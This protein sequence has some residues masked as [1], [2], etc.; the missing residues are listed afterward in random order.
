MLIIGQS[1]VVPPPPQTPAQ[2]QIRDTF[3]VTA[4]VLFL[5]TSLSYATISP[6]SPSRLYAFWFPSVSAFHFITVI[7]LMEKIRFGTCGSMFHILGMRGSDEEGETPDWSENEPP[8][9]PRFVVASASTQSL[10]APPFFHFTSVGFLTTH[11]G[12]ID[13]PS[14]PR[15]RAASH[16]SA[17]TDPQSRPR[18][19]T[20]ITGQ[21]LLSYSKVLLHIFILK[22]ECGWGLTAPRPALPCG[23]AICILQCGVASIWCQLEVLHRAKAAAAARLMKILKGA[24]CAE[25]FERRELT[26]VDPTG[27]RRKRQVFGSHS[28]GAAGGGCT[29][30]LGDLF[31][32]SFELLKEAMQ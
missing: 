27:P 4:F 13:A 1:S 5:F 15:G 19:K 31:S 17:A 23:T 20:H 18:V 32:S 30:V 2:E 9:Y 29:F 3:T 11:A 16:L 12:V 22:K 10:P 21:D 6:S 28:G 26:T 7:T 25:I 24:E 8:S 14:R